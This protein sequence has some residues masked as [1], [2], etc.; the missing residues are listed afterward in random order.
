ME[1]KVATS[2]DKTAM[3]ELESGKQKASGASEMDLMMQ[4][5][6]SPWRE[7]SLEFY[8]KSGWC[9]VALEKSELVGY[10]LAQPLLFIQASTQSLWIEFV[11]GRTL[12]EREELVDVAY[13]WARSKH[14]Q[15]VLFNTKHIEDEILK[16]GFPKSKNLMSSYVNSTKISED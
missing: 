7:E 10:V 1:I 16:N 8:L 9:F 2:E 5:W 4:S 3:F 12:A 14:L 6:D 15:R 11:S 13:R